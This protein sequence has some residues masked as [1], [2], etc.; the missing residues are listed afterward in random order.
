[1]ATRVL[2][3]PVFISAMSPS[4]ST[5][6]PST[7]T[8]KGRMPSARLPASRATA[9]ASNSRSSSSSP[10]SWRWRNSA[11]LA[12]NWS[13]L[14]AATSGS[15][16]VTLW[17]CSWSVLRRRPSP[18]CSSLSTILITGALL[19]ESRRKGLRPLSHSARP[20]RTARARRRN[21]GRRARGRDARGPSGCSVSSR[22]LD[23]PVVAVVAAVHHVRPVGLGV[24]ED[25]EVVARRA[26]S[27]AWPRSPT[28]A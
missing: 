2:P 7:W 12:R 26:P 27:G 10:F 18:A 20:R 22:R 13:S 15:S 28:W 3:S 11:V 9:N 8:S 4:W 25:E 24:R 17:V 14:R 1:M 16:S 23:Q 5:M 19:P 6:P 21:G